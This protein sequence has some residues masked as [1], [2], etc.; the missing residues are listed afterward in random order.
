MS[1]SILISSVHVLRVSAKYLNAD[2]NMTAH[3]VWGINCRVLK[4]VKCFK[5]HKKAFRAVFFEAK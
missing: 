1:T 5:Y 4:S 3:D 2:E